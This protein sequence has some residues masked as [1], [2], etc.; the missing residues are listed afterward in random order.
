MRAAASC[1]AAAVSYLLF[2]TAP[3]SGPDA[4]SPTRKPVCGFIELSD[5]ARRSIVD[6]ARAGDGTIGAPELGLI[7]RLVSID[8]ANAQVSRVRAAI[9][10]HGRVLIRSR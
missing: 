10:T 9:R 1:L 5:A 6:A 4:S 7:E 3:A 8:P 2:V